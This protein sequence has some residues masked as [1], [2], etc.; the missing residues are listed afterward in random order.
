MDSTWIAIFYFGEF[1]N[2]DDGKWIW[3]R[4]GSEEMVDG[5]PISPCT[6][7]HDL[8]C[9]VLNICKVDSSSHEIEMRFLLPRSG[10]FSV[11]VKI[12]SDKQ[13][14]WLISLNKNNFHC[15]ICVTLVRKVL[16]EHPQ[17]E[18]ID[19]FHEVENDE[20]QCELQNESIPFDGEMQANYDNEVN[21]IE[22]INWD[23][24]EIA[25]DNNAR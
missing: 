15:P 3:K 1:I 11:P 23:E 6:S 19:P 8:Y 7:Y 10:Q 20:M 13:V 2:D 18:N 25:Q 12:T 5:I 16:V 17:V 4:S 24:L 21:R 22:N 9:E 14:Q